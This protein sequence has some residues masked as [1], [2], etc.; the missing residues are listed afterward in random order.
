MV[1]TAWT[2]LGAITVYTL[3][4][5]GGQPLYCDGRLPG[6]QPLTYSAATP[7]WIALDVGLYATRWAHCGDPILVEVPGRPAVVLQALDAG[8]FS[9]HCAH[10]GEGEC[11]PIVADVPELHA[12]RLG[13]AAGDLSTYGRIANLGAQNRARDAGRFS[14]W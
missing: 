2:L 11:L 6:G 4:G 1:M 9:R 12:H 13:I 5:Y 10:V 3:A 7:P 8:V 14:P